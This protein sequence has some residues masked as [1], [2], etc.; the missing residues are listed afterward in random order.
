MKAIA[1]SAEPLARRRACG[2]DPVPM[3]PWL[4]APG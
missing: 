4:I 3:G 2:E 1:M